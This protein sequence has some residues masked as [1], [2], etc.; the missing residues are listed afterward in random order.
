MDAWR[1]GTVKKNTTSAPQWRLFGTLTEIP[2]EVRA[3]PR[4]GR[5]S[6]RRCRCRWPVV[7]HATL[8]VR[9]TPY[10]SYFSA[11][12]T[13]VVVCYPPP[14]YSA[15]VHSV[16]VLITG[17]YRARGAAAINLDFCL[18]HATREASIGITAS[19]FWLAIFGLFLTSWS[20]QSCLFQWKHAILFELRRLPF[21]RRLPW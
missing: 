5:I 17:R 16:S 20:L 8:P 6:E 11:H 21:R 9:W 14:K 1:G 2:A 13:V 4:S 7:H 12:A 10:F 3:Q 19:V 15:V 18:R